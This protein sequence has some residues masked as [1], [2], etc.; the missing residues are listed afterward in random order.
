MIRNIRVLGWLICILSELVDHWNRQIVVSIFTNR[1]FLFDW[2]HWPRMGFGLDRY[3]FEVCLVKFQSDVLVLSQLFYSVLTA[4]SWVSK[5]M[6]RL[7]L[8]CFSLSSLWDSFAVIFKGVFAVLGWF[9]YFFLMGIFSDIGEVS[10]ILNFKF[11]FFLVLFNL[12]SH[13]LKILNDFSH[14]FMIEPWD[15]ILRSFLLLNN[16]VWFLELRRIFCSLNTHDWIIFIDL[17]R[18]GFPFCL[19]L[20]TIAW[21]VLFELVDRFEVFRVQKLA[22]FLIRGFLLFGPRPWIPRFQLFIELGWVMLSRVEPMHLYF[23]L[24][25]RK[26]WRLF[27]ERGKTV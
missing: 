25:N 17:V 2:G 26:V 3:S 23:S 10:I 19:I 18:E 27:D 5:R 6:A 12:G 7:V 8:Q 20:S 9:S 21:L 16:T 11:P 14:Q 15:S 13:V 1:V 4:F 22:Y 24:R